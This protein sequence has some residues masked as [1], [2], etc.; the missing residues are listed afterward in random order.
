MP[1]NNHIVLLSPPPTVLP[2]RRI[3]LPKKPRVTSLIWIQGVQFRLQWRIL[4]LLNYGT[5]DIVRFEALNVTRP[6]MSCKDIA[7]YPVASKVVG[8]LIRGLVKDNC[9]ESTEDY[10]YHTLAA[11]GSGSLCL[12]VHLLIC[13][14]CW[15]SSFAKV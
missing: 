1:F 10:I 15:K 12:K 7:G 6:H 2:D 4:R 11:K 14:I 9:V 3:A 5:C 13:G 8:H